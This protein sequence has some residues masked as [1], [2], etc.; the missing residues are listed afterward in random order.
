MDRREVAKQALGYARQLQRVATESIP[1]ERTPPNGSL[2]LFDGMV[3]EP[4]LRD[5]VRQLYIDGHYSQAVEEGFKFLNNLVRRR[6]GCTADGASLMTTALS[7]KGPLLRL[8]DLKTTSQIDQQQG[9]MRMLEGAMLGIRNPRAHE[10]R[11]FD[12]PRNALELLS[13]CN[14][15]VRT[16]VTARRTRQPRQPATKRAGNTVGR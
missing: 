5:E 2:S 11:H 3:T 13:F 10:H 1:A 12:E 15:L 14:H 8:N 6:T 4:E 9:Y 16:V 7:P